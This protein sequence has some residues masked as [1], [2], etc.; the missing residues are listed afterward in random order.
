M[1]R[2]HLF[3][4]KLIRYLC[5]KNRRKKPKDSRIINK[6]V[7]WTSFI[8]LNSLFFSF[9]KHGHIRLFIL[10]VLIVRRSLNGHAAAFLPPCE[11]CFGL[12]GFF[13]TSCE[14]F[15][16]S[17]SRGRTA[18][19]RNDP[20]HDDEKYLLR[21]VIIILISIRSLWKSIFDILIKIVSKN[22]DNNL[23]KKLINLNRLLEF[24]SFEVIEFSTG[25]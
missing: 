20:L 4:F 5:I 21:V 3:R 13:A 14:F 7:L 16:A 12:S 18:V 24:F 2:P 10:I 9:S 19:P 22:I 6:L 25:F 17:W 8:L 11:C 1:A 15:T 23:K